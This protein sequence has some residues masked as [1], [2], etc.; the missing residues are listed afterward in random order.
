MSKFPVRYFLM[1]PSRLLTHFDAIG[2]LKIPWSE[3]VYVFDGI[4]LNW[5]PGVWKHHIDFHGYASRLPV[6]LGVIQ[7]CD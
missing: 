2:V 3:V 5:D 1:C 4:Y 7:R 6:M